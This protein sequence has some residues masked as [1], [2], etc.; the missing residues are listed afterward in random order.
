MYIICTLVTEMEDL[1]KECNSSGE[2]RLES[3]TALTYDSSASL[4]STA[5]RACFN[6]KIANGL[7]PNL[8]IKS[9]AMP[10]GS[11][12]ALDVSTG[13]FSAGT[14]RSFS[15][16]RRSVGESPSA[17]VSRDAESIMTSLSAPDDLLGSSISCTVSVS[18]T[19]VTCPLSSLLASLMA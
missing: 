7:H 18:D 5:L 16:E 14:S 9:A 4:T 19:V 8:A 13:V 11:W 15:D 2:C 12:M 1:K 6:L 17:V 10:A 3:I